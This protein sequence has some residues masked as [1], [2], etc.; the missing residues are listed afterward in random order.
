MTTFSP[1]EPTLD[2][3]IFFTIILPKSIFGEDLCQRTDYPCESSK[4]K[5]D[6]GYRTQQRLSHQKWLRDTPDYWQKLDEITAFS[7]KE[8][9][10]WFKILVPSLYYLAIKIK[11]GL[12][13]LAKPMIFLVPRDRIDLPTRG[14]SELSEDFR[15]Y[16]FNRLCGLSC[17]NFAS[18]CNPTATIFHVLQSVMYCVLRQENFLVPMCSTYVYSIT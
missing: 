7:C 17:M 13:N 18:F 3:L 4:L 15:V 5:T 11:K 6:S 2:Q 1:G 9:Y 8:K 16:N 14:F 10:L 12:S